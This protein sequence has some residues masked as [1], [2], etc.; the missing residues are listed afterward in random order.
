V[1]LLPGAL[2]HRTALVLV[3]ALLKEL[4]EFSDDCDSFDR[5]GGTSFSRNLMCKVPSSVEVEV[6]LRVMRHLH[7]TRKIQLVLY[8]QKGICAPMVLKKGQG[9]SIHYVEMHEV[10]SNSV[11]FVKECS[12]QSSSIEFP[13]SDL[14]VYKCTIG[15]STAHISDQIN[16]GTMPLPVSGFWQDLAGIECE[17][18][19]WKVHSSNSGHLYLIWS[20]M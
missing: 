12:K 13:V 8:I 18:Y 5:R 11:T 19:N 9:R 17:V 14:H 6:L 1:Y 15:K 16:R 7:Y 4:V 10:S 20:D 2:K 3:L